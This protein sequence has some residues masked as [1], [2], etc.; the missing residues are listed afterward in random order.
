[1][2]AQRLKWERYEKKFERQDPVTGEDKYKH[3]F[4]EQEGSGAELLEDIGA[5]LKTFNPHHDLAKQQ[6][7]DWTALKRDFPRGSFVSVQVRLP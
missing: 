3:D 5:K 2:R 7:D 1:M 4:Y 6:D